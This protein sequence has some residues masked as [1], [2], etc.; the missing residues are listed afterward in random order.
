M[1]LRLSPLAAGLNFTK[2]TRRSTIIKIT[3]RGILERDTKE[4]Q[5]E[6]ATL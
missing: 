1:D 6:I 4:L 3:S 5:L 2:L